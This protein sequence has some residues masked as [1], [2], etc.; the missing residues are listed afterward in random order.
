MDRKGQPSTVSTWNSGSKSR[1]TRDFHGAATEVPY[2]IHR[3][4]VTLYTRTP[5]RTCDEKEEKKRSKGNLAVDF[6]KGE[7]LQGSGRIIV[8]KIEA[9]NW[10]RARVLRLFTP[11]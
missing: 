8:M 2:S 6:G 4:V 11:I 1:F 9:H 7:I 3:T 10:I 5:T